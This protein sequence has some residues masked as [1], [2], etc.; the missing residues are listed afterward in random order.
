MGSE[1]RIA[2]GLQEQLEQ[3]IKLITTISVFSLILS[4]SLSFFS[5]FKLAASIP[6]E[7]KVETPCVKEDTPL[8]HMLRAVERY[9]LYALV[10]SPKSLGAA[11]IGLLQDHPGAR[12]TQ[13][14]RDAPEVTL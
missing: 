10:S 3:A 4:V 11:L 9:Q 8:K 7:D 6:P 5:F 1:I 13:C 12:G 14:R 2:D